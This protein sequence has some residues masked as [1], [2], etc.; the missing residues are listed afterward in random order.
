M[1]K[2]IIE[3]VKNI[4]RITITSIEKTLN[5]PNGTITIEVLESIANAVRISLDNLD[6]VEALEEGTK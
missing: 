3:S 2:E 4:S 5:N 1:S 6:R